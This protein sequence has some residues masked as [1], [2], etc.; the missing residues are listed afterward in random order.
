M[1]E[2]VYRTDG[3][4]GHLYY[5]NDGQLDGKCKLLNFVNKTII[6]AI[7]RKGAMIQK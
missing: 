3:Y 2:A 5:N 4:M 1:A 6:Y 7:F